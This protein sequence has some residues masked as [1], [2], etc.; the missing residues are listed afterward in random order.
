MAKDKEKQLVRLLAKRETVPL[1][2]WGVQRDGDESR[3]LC[4]FLRGP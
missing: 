2:L 4:A 1:T 3:A